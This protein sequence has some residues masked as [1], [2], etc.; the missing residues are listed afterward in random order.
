[1]E[2][3]GRREGA[4]SPIQPSIPK[5]S[6]NFVTF[7]RSSELTVGRVVDR[8]RNMSDWKRQEAVFN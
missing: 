6:V 3:L 2:P 4:L 1:M 8:E 5:S 7:S